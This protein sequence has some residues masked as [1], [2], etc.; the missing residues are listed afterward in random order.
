MAAEVA[1]YLQTTKPATEKE[2]PMEILVTPSVRRCHGIYPTW[3][4]T[5]D[6]GTTPSTHVSD[7][8]QDGTVR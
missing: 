1:N 7:T 8:T 5:G 2:I 6:G 3:E 4:M